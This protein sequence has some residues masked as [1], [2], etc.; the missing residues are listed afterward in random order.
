MSVVFKGGYVLGHGI[1][2]LLIENGIIQAIGDDLPGK[3]AINASGKLLVPGFVDTHRHMAQAPLRGFGPDMTLGY[4]MQQVVQHV[5]ASMSVLDVRNSLKLA[6]AEAMNAGVTTVLDWSSVS[7][8]EQVD[9]AIE[10]LHQTGLRVVFGHSNPDDMHPQADAVASLGPDY[11]PVDDVARHIGLAR[12]RGLI[13]SMH[14]GGQQGGGVRKLHD[15]GLLGPDLH[16]VHGNRLEDDEFKMLVDYGSTLTVTPVTELMMGHGDLAYRRFAEAGGEP[17]LGVDVESGNLPDM[18]SE[19]RAGLMAERATGPLAARDLLQA[20]TINGAKAIGLGDAIGS[21]E[22]GKQADI[23]LLSGLEHLFGEDPEVLEGAV[24]T[25]VG[26]EDVHTVL[27]DG[28]VV[29]LDGV[30]VDHDLRELRELTLRIARRTL[31]A[32]G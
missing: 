25:S 11:L 21:L 3:R 12:D 30:L 7:D 1:A 14:V 2:D 9:A 22:V 16:F 27:I 32:A 26:T 6:A 19:M 24:A 23:V 29:K 18:F 5:G 4:Y 28:T 31:A 15:A 8:P 13:T 10:V 20:A 17:A